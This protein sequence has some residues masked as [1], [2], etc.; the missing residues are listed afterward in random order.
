ML[1]CWSVNID[2]RTAEPFS[3][4]ELYDGA[5]PE[6]Q[7]GEHRADVARPLKIKFEPADDQMAFNRHHFAIS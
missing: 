2:A 7:A 6:V 5:L 4:G 3:D 1:H